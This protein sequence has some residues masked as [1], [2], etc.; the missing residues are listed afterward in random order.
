[1]NLNQRGGTLGG[2]TKCRLS[3]FGYAMSSRREALWWTRGEG[4]VGDSEQAEGAELLAELSE[5]TVGVSLGAHHL[6][7]RSLIGVGILGL[8]AS[9]SIHGH[10]RCCPSKSHSWGIL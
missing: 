4:A 1:V 9:A 6:E 7:R 10:M 8:G 2:M 5:G 3:A